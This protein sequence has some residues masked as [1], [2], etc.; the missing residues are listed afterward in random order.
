MEWN[1][2]DLM[3]GTT[4]INRPKATTVNAAYLQH[5]MNLAISGPDLA[6]AKNPHAAAATV[7]GNRT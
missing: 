3:G 6:M 2:A 5:A 4:L 1:R 7:A